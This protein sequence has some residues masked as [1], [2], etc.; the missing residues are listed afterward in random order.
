[1]KPVEQRFKEYHEKSPKTYNAF[2]KYALRAVI[3]CYKH[4]KNYISADMIAHQ[5]RWQEFIESDEKFKLNNSYIS[6]YSRMFQA[7]YP[8]HSHLFRNRQ[9][10]A[11]K[12]EAAYF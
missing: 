1:M 2:V 11:E 9:T 5:V 8:E 4:D 6:Y 3:A 7:D 10:Q 12:A